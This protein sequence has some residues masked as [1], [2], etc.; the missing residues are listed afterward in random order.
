ML[1]GGNGFI[2]SH[3]L[4]LLREKQHDVHLLLRETSNTD[5]IRK[6]MPDV[7]VHYGGLN[8]PDV[9]HTA[10]AAADCIIHCAG[11]TKAL[12]LEEYY[13][14]NRNGTSN[15]VDAA[16]EQA[17]AS[18]HFI[19]I[20]SRA[21]LPPATTDNP[22][23]EETTPDPISDY[24]RSKLEAE[25]AVTS[26]CEVPW[27]ILRPSAV[28]GPRDTDFYGAFRAIKW[29][30]RPLFDG[31]RQPISLA[32]GPD[33][34]AAVLATLGANISHGETYNVAAPQTLPVADFMR[35]IAR[36]MD[37]WT[38]PAYLPSPALYPVCLFHE[39][40]AKITGV[41]GILN[42][43]KYGELTA[44]GWACSVD[45]MR[46]DLGFVCPTDLRDGVGSTLEWYRKHNWL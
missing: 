37:K 11:K 16:N 46:D 32:Y 31:G 13:R 4:D 6:H 20:S 9:L 36:T 18:C 30:I 1:T 40:K 2:G 34:A 29:H 25:Q 42:L 8:Q 14:V 24:G 22:V 5:Y 35:L 7:T 19:H 17:N 27:T 21:V 33:V 23:T 28:F 26:C 15:L 12:S 43:Q 10:V 45:K 44:S 41:P 3:I 39:L 38:I